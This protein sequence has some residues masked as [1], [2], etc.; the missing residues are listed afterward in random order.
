MLDTHWPIT[1]QRIQRPAVQLTQ[2]LFVIRHAANPIAARCAGQSL[3]QSVATVR[4][5]P[6]TNVTIQGTVGCRSRKHVNVVIV[7]TRQDFPTPGI[8][9]RFAKCGG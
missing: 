4:Y 9:H 5:R 8:K 3:G 2:L 6:G 1:T 7:Q